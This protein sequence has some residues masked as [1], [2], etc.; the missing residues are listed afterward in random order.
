MLSRCLL[1]GTYCNSVI[2]N[3]TLIVKW[4]YY[5]LSSGK[6][7]KTFRC[8]VAFLH[9]IFTFVH[10]AQTAKDIGAISFAYDSS[11]SPPDRVKMWLT[12]ANPF[13]S[14]FFSKM[15]LS[16]PCWFE[17]R[18]HSMANCGRMV[19]DSAMVTVKSF[20]FSS[21]LDL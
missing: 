14:K 5:G 3:G 19:R 16:Y 2:L 15:T 17:R 10:C 1:S 13:L 6:R 4:T 21:D 18:R 9:T 12:S 20:H 8:L 7:S 11:M